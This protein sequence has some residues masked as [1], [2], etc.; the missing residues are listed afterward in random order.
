MENKNVRQ[1]FQKAMNKDIA[2]SISPNEFYFHG[3]NIRIVSTNAQS[4]GA[5]TNE[6][7]NSLVISLPIPIIEPLNK[8]IKYAVNGI[9][10]FLPY[11]VESGL[12]LYPR[13]ELESNYYDIGVNTN[14]FYASGNQRLIGNALVRDNIIL[15]STD[16]NGYDCIWKV[17]DSTF[18][19]ELLYMRNLGFNTLN[20]IQCINNFEN[21]EIDKIYWVDGKHQTR[22]VNIHHSVENQDIEELIDLSFNSIQFVGSFRLSQPKVTDVIQGGLH[23]SGVI[24]YAY[25]LYKI[26]G[27]Q[28]KISPLSDLIALN[29]GVT[30]GGGEV[31]EIVGAVPVVSVENLDQTYTN[32]KL[33]A[34]KYTSYNETPEVAVILDRSIVGEDSILY[35]DDGNII[36]TLS[37]EEL[38]FIGSDI[39]IPKHINSKKNILFFANYKERNFDVDNYGNV[40]S[41]DTRAYSFPTLSTTTN[42]Y[43]SLYDNSGIIDSEE[44]AT[45]IN[46]DVVNGTETV[47]TK[48]SAININYDINNKQYNSN[49][50]GGEGAYLKYEIVRNQVGVAN[51]TTKDSEGKFLKD[52]EIYRLGIQFY[53]KYG[54][55]SLP[56]WISDF[57]TI[58]PTDNKCNL[59]GFYASL[60]LTLKSS[61][62]DWLLNDNNFLDENGL[63]DEELR[64]VGY[65]IL[66]SERS[67]LDRTIVCQGLINGMLSQVSGDRTQANETSPLTQAYVDKVNNGIKMPSMMRRFDNNLCPMFLNESYKRLDRFDL[68]HPQ[69]IN[70]F[71]T[72]YVP[73]VRQDAANEVFKVAPLD[74]TIAGTYQFTTLMQMFSPEITFN[75]VQNLSSSN[76]NIVGGLE[77]NYNS[78]WLQARSTETK[79][80]IHEVKVFNS[81]S[82]HDVKSTLP[83]NIEIIKGDKR[84][85]QAYG[86]FG[87][88]DNDEM[89]FVQTN[90][91]Y[92]SNF[93]Y[94]TNAPYE[95][96]GNPEISEI[97]Q[98]RRVYN[99]DATMA[100]FNNL[101]PLAADRVLNTVNSWGA[102]NITFA[103]G[104]PGM[105]T[106]NRPS[107][108]ALFSNTGISDTGVGLVGEFRIPRNL[109][110]LGNIYGGNSYES[111]KR[112]AY[113][114]VGNY[115]SINNNVYNCLHFGDTFVNNFKFTK[116]VKTTTEIYSENVEQVTEIV[117]F[118]VETTVDLKNRNDISIDSWDSRFQPTNEEF[119]KY[120]K[121]YSQEPNLI[122]RRDLDYKFKRINSFD[123]NIIASKPKIPGE[124]IDSWTDVLS[125]ETLTLNGRYGPINSLHNFKEELYSLQD[126]AVAFLS[127]QPRVQINGSDGLEVELGSG[128]VLQEYRY[129]ST[130]SGT[131]N[132]W[133]VV[134]SPQ[135]FYYFDVINK[136]IN[137][138]NQSIVN[139][140]DTKG[141]HTFTT[142]DLVTT[143][144]IKDNPILKEGVSVGYDYINNCVFFTF[145]QGKKSTTLSYNELLQQFESFYDYLPSMYVGRGNNFLA[146]NPENT[147]LFKQY[148][149]NYNQ[150]FNVYYPSYVTVLVNPQ[151]DS[152]TILDNIKYK[153]ELYLNGVDQPNNTLTHVQ[154]YNEYQNS[155][156]IPL[157]FN[158]SGNLRRKFR[159]WDIILPRNSNT[160]QRIRNP[161][162]YLKLQYSHTNN[163]QLI[164]HNPIISYTS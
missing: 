139:L 141:L 140:T 89:M 37:Q 65:R 9:D 134:S 136:S 127:I 146:L 2:K 125:N 7:G 60:K 42:I 10:K 97:G 131:K 39:I 62:Y 23:K 163:Y 126:S 160:R 64:P 114:E 48:H 132:K 20:L 24:Q 83:G 29:K 86:F 16:N 51:F 81:I 144:L 120:N 47:E 52:N 38:L 110:Y 44:P 35:Y 4:T 18:N 28:S 70:N 143:S 59:K 41:I 46:A 148:A 103:L 55:N 93:N 158:R 50:I 90:R 106:T 128:K 147:Q 56:K 40:N 69:F 135:T 107:L 116:L 159:D 25:S 82:P 61:F 91:I 34:I 84:Y 30:N 53:N 5:V 54:Q 1:S 153:S 22:F 19:I 74:D 150:F 113:I 8:R 118:K 156:L 130:E 145:L 88:Q 129:V 75:T 152:D 80:T 92:T 133:S 149:G 98:D 151:P 100:Y 164:L 45:E 109:I 112:S 102:R 111:K 105:L 161:W 96:Y 115:N 121:V 117:E 157:A 99:N 73:P 76:L 11:F 63:L 104:F 94:V 32:I 142:N 31:N 162:N 6:K 123:T 119:Q 26:N 95:V 57:K 66:R 13:N 137:M 33:Y 87:Y 72:N 71:D 108:E 122:L 68:S 15:F 58:V 124:L 78:S 138:M 85:V 12:Q 27:A 154:V 79:N 49:V 43:K 3:Q 67:L 101:K 14:V 155:G 17:N 77:N 36:N 21:E